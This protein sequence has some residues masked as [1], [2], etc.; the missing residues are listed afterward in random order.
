MIQRKVTQKILTALKDTPVVFIRG[1]RQT[2]KSTLVQHLA[3][4]EHR[5]TYVTCD[6][7]TVLSAAASD[8]VGFINGL[9]KP[10]IIDEVQRAPD[11]MLAI[12]ADVDRNRQPGRYLLTGSADVLALPRLA[13]SLA[14]RMELITLWP[15]SRS[16]IDNSE[17]NY[18]DLLFD[19]D[20]PRFP[21]ADSSRKDLFERMVCG[22][23]PEPLLRNDPARRSAWFDAYVTTLL[24][25]DVR[26]LS[27]IQDLTVLPRLL[28]L[29]ATRAGTLLNQ[30][31]MSRSSA[32]PNSTLG[33]YLSVFETIFL[34]RLLPA[35]TSN[36]G[37]RFIKAPKV[38]FVDTGLACHQ[39]GIGPQRLE[40]APDTAGGMFENHVIMELLKQASWSRTWVQFQHFRSLSGQEVDV[41][42][43]NR[44]GEIVAVEIKLTSSPTAKHMKGLKALR[45]D[46]G[47]RFLRGVL[48]Y[49]GGEVIPF[50]D[51][52]LAAPIG[53]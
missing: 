21:A 7:A 29:L 23:Y 10:V 15:L 11:L 4:T 51:R 39:L 19:P 41:V 44:N 36:L 31:E 12:K 38:L 47:R 13:D 45:E 30:S 1:A 40:D 46:A 42:L 16:E 27:N 8:P 22:G 6:N 17:A 37:K 3:L 2:G 32:I 28:R 53:L 9:E 35:W 48:F 25:R 18:I 26:D 14:G 52:L 49:T 34:M 5:A 20:G 50:G 24:E 43:E 33:R